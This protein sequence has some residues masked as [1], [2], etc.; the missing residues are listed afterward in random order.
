MNLTLRDLSRVGKLVRALEIWPDQ[1]P[2]KQRKDFAELNK[3]VGQ[4]HAP[5]EADAQRHPTMHRTDTLDAI[6]YIRGEIYLITDVEEV[7]MQP[8]DTVII[9]GTNHGWSTRSSEPCLLTGSMI[10]AVPLAE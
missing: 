4:V 2:D 6:T 5:S 7:L 1:D 3:G 9:R 10:D 8:G